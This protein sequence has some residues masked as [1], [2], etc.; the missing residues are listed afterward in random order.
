MSRATRSPL[1]PGPVRAWLL[2][3]AAALAGC[4]EVSDKGGSG[5]DSEQTDG[6]LRTIRTSDNS[7][8]DGI[9]KISVE[10]LAGE[11]SMLITGESSK[12]L[13]LEYIEEPNGDQAF[14]WED[15]YGDKSL[16]GAIYPEA[17]D[18]ALN[19]PV[20]ADD[21]P[22]RPGM[23][24]VG[25]AVTTKAGYYSPDT[26]VDLTIQL[27]TDGDTDR[28][29]VR[30]LVVYADGLD[31]DDDV[32]AGTESAVDRWTDV[33][34]AAGI[35]LDV[36]YASSSIDPTLPTM[37]DG[38]SEDIRDIAD[39]AGED[40]DVTVIIG[41]T[42]GNQRNTYGISGGIPGTLVAT[43]RAAVVVSWVANAGGDGTFEEDDIRLYGE[44]LAHEVG[45][46]MGLFHPV[47]STYDYWDALA[48]TPDCTAA[49]RCDDQLGDNNMYPYP[50]CD[51]SS[52]VAQ[53]LITNDQAG[54]SHRYTGAL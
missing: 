8:S 40:S 2:M 29:T 25:L 49:R 48:D 46:Y 47:E 15:W 4:V 39:D 33:W 12:Q 27:K 32:V 35:T 5:G 54:V 34:A 31:Q 16:T 11:T 9:A 10:V 1:R 14:Y 20:R 18:V 6:P 17:N 26:D 23:W 51:W 21:T 3:G 37:Y 38:G 44:T 50:V 43:K 45:H 53:D 52:C 13:S 42:V 41:D 28:A 22:L 24:I 19:W 36:R 7:G 30:A